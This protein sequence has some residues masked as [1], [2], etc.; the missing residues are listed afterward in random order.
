MRDWLRGKRR[1]LGVFLAIAVLVTGGLAWATFEALRL[2]A[3]RIEARAN[4][5]ALAERYDKL[6]LA[7]W[8]LDGWLSHELGREESRPY[9]H[10]SAVYALRLALQNDGNLYSPGSVLEPS[11]LLSTELPD[12]MLLHFQVDQQSG[13]VSPQV[14][15]ETLRQRM[16]AAGI[17][18]TL[19]NVTPRRQQLLDDLAKRLQPLD[20]LE[21]PQLAGRQPNYRD[22]I[23]VWAS[24]NM[25]NEQQAPNPG[26]PQAGPQQLLYQDVA[27]RAGYNFRKKGENPVKEQT[28]DLRLAFGNSCD[29]GEGWFFRGQL[30]NW[31]SAQSTITL[32]PMT[33]LWLKAGEDELLLV[34]RL[35]RIDEK[36]VCQGILLDWPCLQD[37]MTDEVS[38]L[39]PDAR[40]EPVR[41][42]TPL[43]PERT[44]TALPLEIDPGPLE[45]QAASVG[46]TPLR[47]GLTLAWVAAL[48]ALAAVGLG[49]WSLIDLSER[50]IRFVSAVTHEL[51]TPLTTLRLYLDMLTGGL[52]KDEEQKA[53]Y[54]HTLNGE[55]ERLN[56]LVGNVLDFSRLENQRPHLEISP[57][58]VADLLEEVR[59]DWEG[60]C[61]DAGKELVVEHALEDGAAVRT[62]VKLVQQVL[63]NLIDNAC[64]YS[65]EA[66]D[67]RVWVRARAEGRRLVLEVEDRGPGV[68]PRERRAIFRA[69]RRGRGAD[70]TAGGVGL[71]LALADRWASL[72]GGHLSVSC[73]REGAGACFRLKLPLR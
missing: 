57:V 53:E 26:Q 50:R 73:G 37:A 70:V 10:F 32:S 55:T 36:L 47:I 59:S 72:L 42:S 11:P 1:G 29:N 69:F 14:L 33:P 2:E 6:R 4:E 7:L 41:H 68:A 46:W 31:C 22:N 60:R 18:T 34:A 13:W 39:F 5:H 30:R 35:V 63:A 16:E 65:R 3:E 23:L 38:R 51:R 8:S 28:D 19:A 67:R 44:M 52:V 62:D 40:L 17:R 58:I 24:R 56:R 9:N 64:K 21:H 48:M 66:S 54:L 20:L 43:R 25:D 45:V 15:S 12:W 71:G 49:G 27:N 61:H